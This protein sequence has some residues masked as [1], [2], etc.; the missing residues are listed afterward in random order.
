[1]K[2]AAAVLMITLVSA[3]A[4]TACSGRSSSSSGTGTSQTQTQAEGQND[5]Q[6]ENTENNDNAAAATTQKAEPAQE[7]QTNGQ[8][9]QPAQQGTAA[10]AATEDAG[11][12]QTAQEGGGF[13]TTGTPAEPQNAATDTSIS[14]K[15]FT[16][17]VPGDWSGLYEY[18]ESD[19][20]SGAYELT[21]YEASDYESS[22]AGTLFSIVVFPDGVDYSYYPSYQDRGT[23]TAS[24]GTVYHVITVNPT[25][26]QFSEANQSTYEQMQ[27]EEDTVASGITAADGYTY[28]AN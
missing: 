15:Y 22:G 23:L 10:T 27:N 3:A 9:T 16:V 26:V 17:T 4:L 19:L 24:D 12:A 2:K 18:T 8:T 1:M 5:T 25:D 6:T 28:A 14:T 7:T 20:D 11:T 13:E 21:F